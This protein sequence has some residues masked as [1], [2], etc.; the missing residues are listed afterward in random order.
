MKNFKNESIYSTLLTLRKISANTFE[1]PEQLQQHIE[2]I[3]RKVLTSEKK[4][5]FS[6]SC[7]ATYLHLSKKSIDYTIEKHELNLSKSTHKKLISREAFIIHF[8]L[9]EIM[10]SITSKKA[11]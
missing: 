10:K 5:L 8:A 11:S 2:T 7:I 6:K 1:T 4:S 3:L 9:P